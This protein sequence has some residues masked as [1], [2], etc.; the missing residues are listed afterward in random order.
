MTEESWSLDAGNGELHI[1]TGVTGRAA[2]MGH[3]LTMGMQSWRAS[4]DWKAGQPVHAE[5]T[6]DVDSLEV[7][8][9]EG[10]VTPLG[11]P[12]KGIA[13]NNALKSLDA[14]KFPQIRYSSDN[15]AKTD[16]GYRMTGTVEIHGTSRPQVVDV[17]VDRTGD[18][19]N[20]AT[21]VTLT[22]TDFGVKLISLFMGSMKVADELTVE[23]HATY[24]E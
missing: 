12:E 23:F 2:K 3:R 8:K 15:I 24:P 9:G 6:V 14:K 1:L 21:Q 7:L 17:T 22:Q 13:R 4:V 5:L 19:W 10:G 18:S 11:G 20:L 16:T